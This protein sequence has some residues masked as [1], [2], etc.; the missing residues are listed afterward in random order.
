MLAFRAIVPRL[1]IRGD[2]R[3]TAAI[4]VVFWLS[5]LVAGRERLFQDPGT[6][7]HVA[8]GQRILQ[9]GGVPTRDPFSFTF[10]G[11]PWV[12][13][14][15]LAE[16][17]M[18]AMH[19][20]LGWDGLLLVTATLLAALYAWL[21]DRLLRAGLTMVPTLLIVVVA[22]AAGSHHFHVRPHLAT[23]VGMAAT[24][25]L[26]CDVE[27][28]RRRLAWLWLLP[29]G[30]VLWSNLH[31]GVP[32]GLATFGLAAGGWAAARAL[33]WQSPIHRW[34][35]AATIAAV[36]FCCMAAMLMTPY[37]VDT[38]RTWWRIMSLDLPQLIEEHAPL[39]L[40]SPEGQMTVLLG[41]VYLALLA[42]LRPFRPRAT[43]LLPLVWLVLSIG[44]VRHAPLFG[45]VAVIAL[46]DLLPHGRA[47]V[48]LARRGW[49][50][51]PSAHLGDKGR[52]S[53]KWLLVPAACLFIAFG[54]QLIGWRVP[55]VG[56]DW[57]RLNP[58]QW[59]LELVDDLNRTAAHQST[60][61]RLFNSLDLGGF[62]ELHC[63]GQQV[64]ID[65]RC[66]L[67]GGEFL[68][69][70]AAAEQHDPGRIDRWS[71]EYGFS[72]ALVGR[73]SLFD[74]HLSS[75]PAWRL[76]R[77]VPAAALFER[78]PSEGTAR[79]AAVDGQAACPLTRWPQGDRIVTLE[80][81]HLVLPQAWHEDAD[82]GN[83]DG[84]APAP[85]DRLDP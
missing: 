52:A 79:G 17:G 20:A 5:L 12:A 85:G 33:G 30:F 77:R 70:Y 10:G 43:W 48:W 24:F 31:G 69:A 26:L 23:M 14:Q 28:G 22:I 27:A 82:P 50:R 1:P 54:M 63:P 25:A 37:G 34:R 51:A 7:W 29:P 59:P 73:G 13:T 15:W 38:P 35:D 56:R 80:G 42:T 39:R 47:A 36:W 11:Q 8:V 49:W 3:P 58:D 46:A 40:S 62:V 83:L 65:D 67:F 2:L 78:A 45:L 21:A 60:G 84:R 53:A 44:R 6:F 61:D 16:C 55:L 4:F 72:R 19:G 64:F 57:A 66:E 71:E 75:S 81:P 18:A 9:S 41:I 32:A 68:R 74:Q 76:V